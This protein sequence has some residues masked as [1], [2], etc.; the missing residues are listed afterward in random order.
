M[1]NNF[2]NCV[3]FLFYFRETTILKQFRLSKILDIYFS[4]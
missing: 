1:I 3:F 2:K 4:S